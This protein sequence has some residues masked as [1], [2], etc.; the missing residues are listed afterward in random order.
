MPS[1]TRYYLQFFLWCLGLTLVVGV[2]AAL[3]PAG[4][5]GILTII[6]Y[7][8]PI[9]VFKST[10]PCAKP[11]GKKKADFGIYPDILGL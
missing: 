8:Y 3:L 7:H 9:Q 11:A 6:P 5:G 1:L 2:V 10:G 4:L